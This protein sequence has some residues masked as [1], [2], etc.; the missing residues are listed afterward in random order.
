M[1]E[2]ERVV[3]AEIVKV[4]DLH[5]GAAHREYSQPEDSQ[6]EGSQQQDQPK[7][8]QPRWRLPLVLFLA[9]CFSTYLTGG[10]AFATALMLI[11]L[12]HEFG[13]FLQARRYGV[14]A[15]L[16]CFI[17]MPLSPIGTMG[18]V[19][20]MQPGKGTRRMVF[21]IGIS[22]PIAGFFPAVFFSLYGL[23]QSEIV[24]MKDVELGL[25]LGEPLIF[26]A[27]VYWVLGPLPEGWDVVLHPVAYAGWVG[28]FITALNLFPIGQLDGGHILYCLLR[29]RS[30]SVAKLVLL[31]CIAA[32]VYYQY[33]GWV[34]MLSLL[35]WMGA[36]HPKTANDEEELGAIRIFLGWLALLFMP[37]GFTPVPFILN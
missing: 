6:H 27:M 31:G 36:V 10:L 9:T 5:S 19:I 35:I 7:P 25:S 21:D 4:E 14:P 23:Y 1:N 32:V 15:S 30:H 16:P 29:K 18:A 12:A 24:N 2:P 3:E 17:P 34:L 37:L 28:I 22:G 13:H 11:L 26:K 20:A 8:H 33:W